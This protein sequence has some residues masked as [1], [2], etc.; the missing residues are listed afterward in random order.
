VGLALIQFKQLDKLTL[1]LLEVL[2]LILFDLL[3]TC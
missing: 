3:Q 1:E 2:D